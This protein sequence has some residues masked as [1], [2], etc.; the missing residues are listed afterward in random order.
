MV[1]F[2]LMGERLKDFLPTI[3]SRCVLERI[4]NST[5]ASPKSS[6]NADAILDAFNSRNYSKL[7]AECLKLEK[8]FT[9]V[10]LLDILSVLY[11]AL[12][13]SAKYPSDSPL[14]A[15]D[16]LKAIMV[17][18]PIAEKLRAGVNIGAGHNSGTLMVKLNDILLP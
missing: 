11:L 3:R 7:S 2:I 1:M 18:S 9:R 13:N 14:Y 10:E 5:T 8:G 12:A 17:V 15:E 16:Y 6:S 4:G